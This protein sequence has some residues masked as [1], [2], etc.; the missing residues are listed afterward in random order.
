M[1]QFGLSKHHTDILRLTTD[2][3]FNRM[4][5]SNAP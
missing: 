5:P 3:H 4:R 2:K 1:E